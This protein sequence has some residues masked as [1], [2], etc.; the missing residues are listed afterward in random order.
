MILETKLEKESDL[1]QTPHP[2]KSLVSGG[3]KLPQS[4][5]A[6]KEFAAAARNGILADA[7]AADARQARS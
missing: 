7:C 1:I 5:A 3:L 4:A 6:K 2:Q